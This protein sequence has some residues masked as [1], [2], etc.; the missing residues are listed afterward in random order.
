MTSAGHILLIQPSCGELPPCSETCC[1]LNV[2]ASGPGKI[3]DD[4]ICHLGRVDHLGH[5]GQTVSVHVSASVKNSELV[6]EEAQLD[7]GMIRLGESAI[8]TLTVRNP[9]RSPVECSVELSP[10]V[11]GDADVD[12]FKFCPSSGTILPLDTCLIQVTFS[13]KW[14]R[15]VNSFLE[16]VAADGGKTVVGVTADVQHPRVCLLKSMVDM[17]AYLDVKTSCTA[18]LFNQT[19]LS[20]TF[21]WGEVACVGDLSVDVD[22]EPKSGVI[23]ARQEVV[24][25]F[26]I[27]PHAVGPTGMLIVPCRVQGMDAP[28][29]FSIS[30]DVHDLSVT[31]SVSVDKEA[32]Q[33][34]PG[35]II[36]FGGNNRLDDT[37]TLYLRI[38][39]NSGIAAPFRLAVEFYP[40]AATAGRSNEEAPC[41]RGPARLLKK[42]AN[43]TDPTAKTGAKMAKERRV[44]MLARGAG[45]AFH[46]DRS[47]GELAAFSEVVVEIT[48]YADVWGFYSDWLHCHV[49]SLDLF[50]I[51]ITMTTTGC[52]VLFQM[53]SH[54]RSLTPT[55]RFGC[56][57][58]GTAPITR[59]T[60]ILNQSPIDIRVDW[61]VFN[62]YVDDPQLL[63]LVVTYGSPFP[64]M[65]KNGKEI[66]LQCDGG[67]NL[68]EDEFAQLTV[69]EAAVEELAAARPRLISLNIRRHDG[70]EA[71]TPYSIEPSQLVR[72]GLHLLLTV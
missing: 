21:E 47:S 71:T 56:V 28:V 30:A 69:D 39:N 42:T 66:I 24:V 54:D 15:S 45:V 48:A 38:Q 8:R 65:D 58:E 53:V 4:I 43:V 2:S 44:R 25:S 17:D 12:E 37:P 70:K 59:R 16:V 6:I 55:L 52:P 51:P 49:G 62:V 1:E 20:T 3:D 50:S 63:Y 5:A 19:A 10:S 18:V 34:G 36:D 57:V 26:R 14:C 35:M 11:S 9:E 60:R 7:F 67:G 64:P 72:T 23:E 13:P 31:C 29:N 68:T 22:V 27:T 32:W 61:Q 40:S 33:T 46:L 41:E